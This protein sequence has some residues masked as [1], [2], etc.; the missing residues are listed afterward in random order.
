M[1][2]IHHLRR[3]RHPRGPHDHPPHQWTNEPAH[4]MLTS[5]NSS[6]AAQNLRKDKSQ[7][8]RVFYL[9]PVCYL[10]RDDLIATISSLS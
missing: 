9:P 2:G 4:L 3:S 1:R 8:S 10:G 7:T 5:C 6:T